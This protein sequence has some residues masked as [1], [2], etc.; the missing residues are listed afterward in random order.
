MKTI[1]LLEKYNQI[2]SSLPQGSILMFRMG[3]FY[4]I[5]GDNAKVAAPIMGIALTSRKDVPMCGVPVWAYESYTQKLIEKGY[6]IALHDYY[7]G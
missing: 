5:F 3:D 2:Q 7:V 6:S 1:S 4:E